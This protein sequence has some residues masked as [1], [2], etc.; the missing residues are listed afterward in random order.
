[1]PDHSWLSK[2]RARLPVEVHEA[3]FAWPEF[4]VVRK[5]VGIPAVYQQLTHPR[6][7]ACAYKLAGQRLS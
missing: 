7:M 6:R 3:V 1:V 2:T 4:A 5:R